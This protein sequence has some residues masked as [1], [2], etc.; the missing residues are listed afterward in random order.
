VTTYSGFI[1]LIVEGLGNRSLGTELLA[2]DRFEMVVKTNPDLARQFHKPGS[3]QE[4]LG[5]PPTIKRNSFADSSFIPV[6]WACALETGAR[7]WLER[8]I[9]VNRLWTTCFM[10]EL[11]GFWA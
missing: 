10:G 5:P 3:D 6:S 7:T 1:L 2:G 8:R 4:P 11:S 9:A